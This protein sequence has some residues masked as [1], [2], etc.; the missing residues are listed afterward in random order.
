LYLG[1]FTNGYK[2]GWGVYLMKSTGTY[3]KTNYS[4]GTLK[5]STV[6]QGFSG[7]EEDNKLDETISRLQ[8]IFPGKVVD[9]NSK[10]YEEFIESIQPEGEPERVNPN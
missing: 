8:S 2:N 9:V 1:G 3:Y 7:S 6:Y 10:E 5:S 4:F